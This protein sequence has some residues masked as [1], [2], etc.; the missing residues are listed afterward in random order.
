MGKIASIEEAKQRDRLVEARHIISIY[1]IVTKYK[2]KI[3]GSDQSEITG[4]G[5]A[6][7]LF[8]PPIIKLGLC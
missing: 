8:T 2:T 3:P 4:S 7:R 5:S 6:T 1:Y